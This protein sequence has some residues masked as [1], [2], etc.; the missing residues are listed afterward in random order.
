[1]AM[2]A[3]QRARPVRTTDGQGGFTENLSSKTTLYGYISV[4]DDGK[5]WL[6][7]RRG[8]DVRS[9][10]VVFAPY[11]QADGDYRVSAGMPR[12][13]GGSMIAYELKRDQMPIEPGVGG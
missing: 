13:I 12:T 4:L 5:T 11:G 3:I 8:S 1:M 9:E 7:V 6:I 10:D 2:Q